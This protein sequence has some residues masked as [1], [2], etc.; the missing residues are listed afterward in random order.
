M[1]L[2]Q[3]K[4]NFTSI[5]D[6][7]IQLSDVTRNR[8]RDNPQSNAAH[9]GIVYRKSQDYETILRFIERAGTATSHEVVNGTGIVL[10]TVSA[11]LS[12][13]KAMNRLRVTGVRRKG[14]AELELV[15]QEKNLGNVSG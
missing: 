15:K 9:E 8:H 11:R 10:Q 12:E 5:N 6:T 1:S 13:L 4:F 2:D 3:Q 14:A 7:L